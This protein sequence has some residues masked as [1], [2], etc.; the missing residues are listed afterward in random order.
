MYIDEARKVLRDPAASHW[1]QEAIRKL[2]RRDPLDAC[3]DVEELAQL[4]SHRLSEV[5][6]AAERVKL[7][8]ATS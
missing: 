6:A 3:R 5:V 8:E 1:L 4:A 2:Q 7:Y